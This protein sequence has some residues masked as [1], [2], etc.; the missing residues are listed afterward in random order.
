MKF[1]GLIGRQIEM[2]KENQH[3]RFQITRLI[4]TKVDYL[5][6]AGREEEALALTGEHQYLP[7]FMEMLIDRVF[8]EKDFDT[9]KKYPDEVLDLYEDG[10]IESVKQTGRKVYRQ[11]AQYLRT[12]KNILGGDER[13]YALLKK[14]LR[15]Y[16]NRPAMKDEFSKVFPAWVTPKEKQEKSSDIEEHKNQQKFRL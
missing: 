13:A 4:K 10:I 2:E 15:E 8:S 3:S 12:I 1:M 16:S 7:D 6:R 5:L 11:V 14:F 9:A